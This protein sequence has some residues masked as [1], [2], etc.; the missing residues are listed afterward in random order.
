MR[1]FVDTSGIVAL[2]WASDANHRAAKVVWKKLLA[3]RAALHTSDLV[4]AES[5]ALARARAG[6][7][8]ALM[9]WTSLTSEPFEVVWT[10]A[11][12]LSDAKRIFEKYSDHELSLC[13]CASAAAMR[14]RNIR[15]AFAFDRDFETL[16]FELA[17]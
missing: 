17:K 5:V 14:A 4:V 13:D 2:L 16:G 1:V 8:V 6:F 3:R 12:L 11:G 9:A 7:D 15:L 10:D